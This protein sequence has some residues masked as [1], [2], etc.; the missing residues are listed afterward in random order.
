MVKAVSLPTSNT[1]L[2]CLIVIAIVAVTYFVFSPSLRNGFVNWDD[3]EYVTQN[4]M[5]TGDAIPLKDIFTKP[6]SGNYHPL[7][8]LLYAIEYKFFGLNA[9][10]YHAV[11]LVIHLLNVVLV[12]YVVLLLSN[13]K[14]IALMAA[15]LFG[16]HPLHVESV[17]WIAE[18]KDVQYT[19]FFFISIIFYLK[20][21]RQRKQLLYIISIS[22]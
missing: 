2:A 1:K 13:K 8:M 7:T 14:T 3:E 16:I 6:V 19:F 12:F 17:A 11:N 18:L 4:P 15:L 9:T 21:I 5:V 22:F 10:G 20:F